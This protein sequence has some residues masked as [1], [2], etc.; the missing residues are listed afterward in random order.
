M[1]DPSDADL[2]V[3]ALAYS[4]AQAAWCRPGARTAEQSERLKGARDSAR[5]ALVAALRGIGGHWMRPDGTRYDLDATSGALTVSADGSGLAVPTPSRPTI[6][7]GAWVNYA[8]KGAAS[9]ATTP[10][11]IP[12]ADLAAAFEAAS[13]EFDALPPA[14][15]G[16]T[17]AGRRRGEA[18][19]RLDEARKALIKGLAAEPD[20]RWGPWRLDNL[21]RLDRIGVG[22]KRKRRRAS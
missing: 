19:R 8:R 13:R 22:H 18:R 21:G 10:A 7:G 12:T 15:R 11:P 6:P 17:A 14:G 5:L 4:H 9:A 20:R 1:S 16:N 3:L 2:D